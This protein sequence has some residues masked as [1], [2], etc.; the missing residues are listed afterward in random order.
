MKKSLNIVLIVVVAFVVL[1]ITAGVL[2]SICYRPYMAVYL[3]TGNIYFGK[4][5]FF[6]C[7]KMRDPWFLQQSENGG[8]S[9][10]KFSDAVWA[11]KG[12]MKINRKQ[13]V[14]M[15]KLSD[16]SPIIATM[17]GRSLPSQQMLQNNL[18]ET[19]NEEVKK[20]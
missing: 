6:P 1:A 18:P 2:F 10:Q 5:S 14:F 17:E 11:P 13:I 16:V 20:D 4:T 12:G 9:L 19:D 8:L 3:T 15:S 7:V